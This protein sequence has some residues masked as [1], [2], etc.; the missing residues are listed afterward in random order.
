M[1]SYDNE[2]MADTRQGVFIKEYESAFVSGEDHGTEAFKP[3]GN[4][5]FGDFQRDNLVG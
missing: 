1:T 3:K 2:E 4:I 5:Y